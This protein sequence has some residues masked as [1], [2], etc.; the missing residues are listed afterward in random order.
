M[1]AGSFVRVINESKLRGN[2]VDEA[3]VSKN[4]FVLFQ[5][6]EYIRAFYTGRTG[7]SRF[8]SLLIISGAFGMFRTDAVKA[9]GGYAAKA[10]G[11][12][13]ELVTRLHYE[14]R[15]RGAPYS[16]SYVPEAVCWT[17]VP[18]TVHSL[19]VQRHRWQRGLLDSLVTHGSML[20]NPRFGLIGFM[21]MPY[22]ALVEAFGPLIEVFLWGVLFLAHSRGMLSFG[23]WLAFVLV[24]LAFGWALSMCSLCVEAIAFHRYKRVRDFLLLTSAT[25]LEPFGYRQLTAVWRLAGTFSYLRGNKHWGQFKRKGFGQNHLPTKREQE[26]RV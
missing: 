20:F 18:S 19:Y 6:V 26:E 4:P 15:R 24:S 10:I 14:F 21:A 16:M 17:E 7:W 11:E 9:V 5:V 3:R 12:D 1:A 2:Q 25:I 13:M 8:N 22:F 23:F